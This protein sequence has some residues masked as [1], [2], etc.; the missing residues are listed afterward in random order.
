MTELWYLPNR[1][2]V[3][4]TSYPIHADYRDV[5]EIFACLRDPSLPEFMR[6][7]VALRL[8]FEGQLPAAHKEEAMHVLHRFLICGQEERPGPVLMDWE[9][10]AQMIVADVNRVAGQEIRQL[11][12]VHWWTFLSWFHGV[13][14]GQLSAVVAIRDKLR[15]GKRLEPWEQEFYRENRSRVEL[16]K[17]YT[18]QELQEQE[19]LKQ[20][21]GQQKGREKNDK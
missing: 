2:T 15:R 9:Q 7:E 21:L 20:L 18:L 19:R 10:D 4:G 12:F 16:K 3:G 6:W 1:L 17:R 11:P 13:G 5:L 8:F 14:Q